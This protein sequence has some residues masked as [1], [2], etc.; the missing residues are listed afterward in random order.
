[1][2]HYIAKKNCVEHG[3][4]KPL[5]KKGDI[6]KEAG[7][8]GKGYVYVENFEGDSWCVGKRNSKR[9]NSEVEEY[10]MPKTIGEAVLRGDFSFIQPITE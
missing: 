4:N 8:T 3:T 2:K 5:C 10:D 7:E 9:F 1:M 6:L